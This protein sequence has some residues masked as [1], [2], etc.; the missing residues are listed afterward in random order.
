MLYAV[1]TFVVIYYKHESAYKAYITL[2]CYLEI[3]K[4]SHISLN[5]NST[6][7]ILI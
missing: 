1:Q 4:F 7:I 3:K 5:V 2:Q 6:K